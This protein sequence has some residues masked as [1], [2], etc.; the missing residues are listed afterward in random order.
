MNA[1]D[2]AFQNRVK[3]DADRRAAQQ[4]EQINAYKLK[5]QQEVDVQ[6][7][8]DRQLALAD[9][10]RAREA[11]ISDA[12]R[13]AQLRGLLTLKTAVSKGMAPGDA[14]KALGPGGLRAFGDSF[15]DMATFANQI[16]ARPEILDARIAG[17]TGDV[18]KSKRVFKQDFAIGPDGKQGVLLTYDDGTQQF[19]T[20]YRD[21]PNSS[22]SRASVKITNDG[23]IRDPYTGTVLGQVNVPGVVQQ[24]AASALGKDLGKTQATAIARLPVARSTAET[25]LQA[26]NDVINDANLDA[27][28][29]SPSFEKALGQGGLAGLTQFLG[30]FGVA[31]GSPA[32]E[33][34]AKLEFVASRTFLDGIQNLKG[35]GPVTEREGAAAQAAVANL[36]RLRNPTAIRQELRRLA[37]HIQRYYAALEQEAAGAY[38]GIQA[39][40]A[41]APRGGSAPDPQAEPPAPTSVLNKYSKYDR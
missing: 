24:N 35:F 14:I 30:D 34:A 7:D 3:F 27:I 6:A 31:P 1:Y 11:E 15:G 25:S 38:T 22:G 5:R 19:S 37:G 17:L 32:A 29:G 20:D 40:G 12:Q 2:A 39:P 36:S 33:A 4:A 16:A 13:Q 23:M 28:L 41:G 9:E 10:A 21:V 26:I 8:A 18:A